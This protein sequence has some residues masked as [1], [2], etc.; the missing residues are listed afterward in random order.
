MAIIREDFL[1]YRFEKAI[2]KT[3]R[4]EFFR[5]KF[6]TYLVNTLLIFNLLI[7]FPLALISW[8][9]NL[10]GFYDFAVFNFVSW[11]TF[12]PIWLVPYITWH[13][14]TITL[15]IR[16]GHNI[17]YNWSKSA[18][19]RWISGII[20]IATLHVLSWCAAAKFIT[21]YFV[22]YLSSVRLYEPYKNIILTNDLDSFILILYVAPVVFS[23]I[24]SFLQ[25]RDYMINKDLLK[26][27]F[28]Q[29]QTPYFSRYA[30]EYEFESCDIIVGYEIGTKKP[31]VIKESRRFLHEA[32]IGATGSGKT[33]TT[34]LLRI[35]QDVLKIATGARKMGILFLEPKG[36][37]VD[38]VLTICKKLGVPDEKIKVID[39]T[40][41][42]SVKYNPFS[43]ARDVAAQSFQGTLNA[44]TGDQDEFFK[45]QQNEAASAYTLLAK[46]RFG[47]LTNVTHIQRMF[48]DPRYL[49]DIVEYVRR[50][51]DS[52]RKDPNLNAD[53]YRLAELDA[54]EQTV[55]YFENEVLDYKTY[56]VKDAIEKV[57]Y[58][59][60]HR[61]ANQQVVENK[62][63]KFVTGAKKYLNEIALNSLLKS[64]FITGD[65]DE[66]FDADEFLSNG[67]IVLVNTCLA[68]LD[69]LSLL[70]GQ[71]FIRQFQSAVFR[72][73]KEDKQNNVERIPISFYVDEFPL[74]ANEAFERFLTLGRSYNI[75][76]MIAMQSIAQLDA[77]GEDYRK[78]VLGNT[79][80]KT[81]FGRGPVE[82]NEYFSKEFGEYLVIEESANESGSP[83]TSEDQKWGFRYNTQKKLVPRFTPTDIRGLPFKKMIVQKVDEDNNIDLPK[84]A[85]GQFVHE[86]PFL[87]RFMDLVE[88]DIKSTHEKPLVYSDHLSS[89]GL[90]TLS[91]MNSN[92]SVEA[93]KLR[94]IDGLTEEHSQIPKEV[95]D[96][97]DSLRGEHMMEAA[98]NNG[99]PQN[100][101]GTNFEDRQNQTAPSFTWPTTEEQ[102]ETNSTDNESESNGSI[103]TGMNFEDSSNN[104]GGLPMGDDV[105]NGGG[106]SD[107]NENLP[108]DNPPH[109]DNSSVNEQ[110]SEIAEKD[111][112]E[113]DVW[114]QKLTASTT[115]QIKPDEKVETSTTEESINSFPKPNINPFDTSNYDAK[116]KPSSK[117]QLSLFD[118]SV[119]ETPVKK[120]KNTKQTQTKQEPIVKVENGEAERE[121]EPL[122]QL[123]KSDEVNTARGSKIIIPGSNMGI[124]I[125][126]EVEDDI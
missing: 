30:H 38:D 65:G 100:E 63:D 115:E 124:T 1:K 91:V 112:D 26:D 60:D 109:E 45:G 75:S 57:L 76:V 2:K 64:L 81:V 27:H 108:M 74:Y 43:G 98:L 36:D 24:A 88:D 119:E 72:R 40:K 51:I 11:W 92:V 123:P 86:S 122:P 118:A 126:P 53:A 69:E 49:A 22:G 111:D 103:S 62:K 18:K 55:S 95:F 52:A 9:A 113:V 20:N 46:I 16:E 61:Y 70:F 50:M 10:F 83:M 58:P 120:D 106:F 15:P 14:S 77:V 71:F 29:W 7:L 94:V 67:G 28:S 116:Q 37:G 93:D 6:N 80:N 90:K 125:K 66:A 87:K 59:P 25:I 105:P 4:E 85:V 89:D 79:S 102:V 110:H 3:K 8:L 31:I 5:I 48:T 32:V 39:P 54:F 42:W 23:A 41:S 13:Y 44:L 82:D 47:P 101:Q 33:S 121:G 114:E 35:A 34:I 107:E 104:E 21:Q 97:V 84:L 56:R 117:N 68:E 19:G 17:K 99:T 96:N 73:A 12:I 78:S